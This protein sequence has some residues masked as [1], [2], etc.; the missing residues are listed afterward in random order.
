M[1][2]MAAD[3]VTALCI[4]AMLAAITFSFLNNPSGRAFRERHSPVATAS[5]AGFFVLLYGTIRF[6]WGALRTE[7]FD[8]LRVAGLILML[9]GTAFNIWGRVHLKSNWADHVRIYEDQQLITTGPYRIVRH[10]LYA[11]LI[12]M[13]YGASMAYLNPLAALENT[14]LF[15]PA[16][17]YRSN[18]EEQALLNRFGDAYAPYRNRTGRFVPRIGPVKQ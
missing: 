15:L 1:L 2:N 13:F 5:M 16:M 12:W 6:R 7:D 17:I 8:V 4:L 14:V 10:P 3:A 9:W 18:L 11:S